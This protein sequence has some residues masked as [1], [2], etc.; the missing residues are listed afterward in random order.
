M[1]KI[2]REKF[3]FQNCNVVSNQHTVTDNGHEK[4]FYKNIFCKLKN[5]NEM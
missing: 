1:M 3:L 2:T 5:M 4:I